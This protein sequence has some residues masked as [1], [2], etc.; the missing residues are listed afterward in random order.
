MGTSVI[1]I[2]RGARWGCLSIMGPQ[3]RLSVTGDLGLGLR[4]SLGHWG[5]VLA[6]LQNLELP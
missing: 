5:G 4:G 2:L 3:E 6:V 1:L